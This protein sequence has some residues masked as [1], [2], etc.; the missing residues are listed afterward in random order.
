MSAAMHQLGEAKEALGEHAAAV[1]CYEACLPG[2]RAAGNRILEGRTLFNLGRVHLDLGDAAAALLWHMQAQGV[3]ETLEPSLAACENQA[4]VALCQI[5]LGQ[6]NVALA[7]VNTLLEQLDGEWA[8]DPPD[9]SIILR[10]TCQQVLEATAD[11]RAA[12]LLQQLFADVQV[13]AAAMTDA[14]DRD[15]LIQAHPELRVIV[16]AWSAAAA[17]RST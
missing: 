11:A 4:C 10:W 9:E 15:R 14:A 6:P 1:R 13:R 3:Y 16:A 2:C 17:T 5:R 12:P 8:Q 7:L